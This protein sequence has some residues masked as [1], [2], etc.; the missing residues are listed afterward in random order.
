MGCWWM[1]EPLRV[2][3]ESEDGDSIEKACVSF[4]AL[5][6]HTR[7]YSDDIEGAFSVMYTVWGVSEKHVRQ[8]AKDVLRSGLVSKAAIGEE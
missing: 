8:W 1:E 6:P 2:V 5:F 7:Y 4:E 3:L